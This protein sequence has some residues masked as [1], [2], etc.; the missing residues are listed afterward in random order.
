VNRRICAMN[1]PDQTTGFDHG[2]IHP[3]RDLPP[4]PQKLA[5]RNR[6]GAF[7]YR[8]IGAP[9]TKMNGHY[10]TDRN[11]NGSIQLRKRT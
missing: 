2:G 9:P 8:V 1:E 6:Y 4:I 11:T 7:Q 3:Q 5:A 10:W